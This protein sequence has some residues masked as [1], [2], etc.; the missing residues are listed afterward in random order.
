MSSDPSE[1]LENF[2]KQWKEEVTARAKGTP[3]KW[4]RSTRP[5]DPAKSTAGRGEPPKATRRLPQYSRLDDERVARAEDEASGDGEPHTYHDLE[6]KDEARRLGSE[7]EGTH[8]SVAASKKPSS[9]LEHYERAVEREEQGN[10]GDSVSLY[11]KAYRLDAGVD[12]IYRNKHFPPTSTTSKPTN[13]NPSNAPVTVPGTAHHSLDGPPA[14][15]PSISQLIAS[16]A[17]HSIP[18]VPPETEHSPQPPCPISTVP[19]ELLIGIL[20]Y[21]A[22]AD[23]ASFSR[24]SLVCK[25][26]AY[27]VATEDSIWQHIC[28]GP[29]YGFAG[30][31][32]DWACSISGAA[33]APD[34][35]DPSFNML[36]GSLP[37]PNPEQNT[38]T[39]LPNLSD[40]SLTSRPPTL[41]FPLSPTYPS[42]RTMFRTRPRLRFN[43]CYIS[44]VNY[45]RPGSSTPSQVSWNTP[46]HIVTYY[47]YLRFFRDGSC[48]SLLTTSE[49]L[50]VVHHL[51]KANLPAER[52]GEERARGGTSLLPPMSIMQHAL[53]GRWK[54]SPPSDPQPSSVFAG[55][56]ATTTI[57]EAAQQQE[58]EGILTV[59]TEGIDPGKYNY[60]MS[61]SVRSAGR[62]SGTRNNKLAWKGFWSY[63]K[64]TDDWAEFGLRNDRAF[65]WSRV[66]SYGMGE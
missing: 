18:P 60:I 21:L 31:H 6:D 33:Q 4:E 40:L 56:A 58:P 22:I 46:V 39:T 47:R 41:T 61:L 29:K 36:D 51:C 14:S 48:V 12:R 24:L 59:E 30:M 2:R 1:E 66:G 62:A 23:V 13:P 15:T 11:R 17:G 19:S 49:P 9:A 52:S 32:Y 26:L 65:F 5:S 54:L 43:G 25:H 45:I 8:P 16:F 28:L 55:D 42:H 27:L 35:L 10:L 50:D 64:L 44:T 34:E 3:G 37:D 57:N 7:G 20:F 63:N 38:D 53:R